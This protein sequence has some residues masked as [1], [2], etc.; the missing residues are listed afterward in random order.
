MSPSHTTTLQAILFCIENIKVVVQHNEA[1]IF[2]PYQPEIQEFVPALQVLS[3][4]FILS[5]QPFIV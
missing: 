4:T 5:I 3:R 1:L 2:S